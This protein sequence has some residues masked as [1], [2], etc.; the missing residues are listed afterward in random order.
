M[1]LSFFSGNH[2]SLLM[3]VEVMLFGKFHVSQEFGVH[4]FQLDALLSRRLAG[5]VSMVF[6]VLVVVC[7]ILGLGHFQTA[8]I[9]NN[10]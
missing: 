3:L 6:S 1:N 2:F 5:W 9:G 10:Q 8:I 7:V 4:A